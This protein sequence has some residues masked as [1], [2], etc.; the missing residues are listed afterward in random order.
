MKC[1]LLLFFTFFFSF[2]RMYRFMYFISVALFENASA[3]GMA[4]YFMEETCVKLLVQHTSISNKFGAMN[5]FMCV[6]QRDVHT[7]VIQICEC[8]CW[9]LPNNIFLFAYFSILCFYGWA[10]RGNESF[11]S[12]SLHIAICQPAKL[13]MILYINNSNNNRT[14]FVE[15]RIYISE[16]TEY[17]N[18]EQ[19][20][21][22]TNI[23]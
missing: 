7:I 15:I 6:G 9:L 10:F 3:H 1:F 23:T 11:F 13:S 4:K 8:I 20:W 2:S 17:K 14:C 22:L 16:H 21:W 19:K 12:V 18:K 5:R